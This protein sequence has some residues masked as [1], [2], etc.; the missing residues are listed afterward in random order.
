MQ[1]SISPPA[2]D[3]RVMTTDPTDARCAACDNVLPRAGAIC[4]ACDV[5][6]HFEGAPRTA[7]PIATPLS[8]RAGALPER[9]SA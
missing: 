7:P 3:N 9:T 4:H 6:R 8:R 5:E 2:G 1:G